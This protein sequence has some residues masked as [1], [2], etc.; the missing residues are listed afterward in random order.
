MFVTQV[1]TLLLSTK[2]GSSQTV[3]VLKN[4]SP[5]IIGSRIVGE[6]EKSVLDLSDT[7]I[8]QLFKVPDYGRLT[9][10]SQEFN[11]LLLRGS[12]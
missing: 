7:T 5:F 2:T 9:L 10:L 12:M 4:F 3:W 1:V 11:Y 8:I 6:R